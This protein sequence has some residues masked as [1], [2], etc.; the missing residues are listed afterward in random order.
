M[1]GSIDSPKLCI[2]KD[3]FA[4]P[5]NNLKKPPKINSHTINY[6][7]PALLDLALL[8]LNNA[9]D[10]DVFFDSLRCILSKLN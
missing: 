7:H 3:F 1:N 6:G 10:V 9:R 8:T 4:V 2:W 5:S